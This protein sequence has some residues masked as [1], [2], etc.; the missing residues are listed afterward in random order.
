MSEPVLQFERQRN[1]KNNYRVYHY[2]GKNVEGKR[3]YITPRLKVYGSEEEAKEASVSW[4]D[5]QVRN[6]QGHTRYNTTRQRM[7]LVDER[8]HHFAY[9]AQTKGPLG[10]IYWPRDV[11]TR[12]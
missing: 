10:Y 8:E 12:H 5:E 11:D 7:Y 2:N 1:R 3:F 6:P 4:S 9:G